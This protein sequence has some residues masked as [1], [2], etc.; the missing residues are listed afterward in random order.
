MKKILLI[1]GWLA[2]VVAALA[3]T[4][5]EKVS[6]PVA[7]Q[8]DNAN[9]MLR[10]APYDQTAFTR[11]LGNHTRAVSPLTD[12]CAKLSVAVFTT[13]G[14]K[15][16]NITQ[17]VGDAGYGT[18][19]LSLSAGTYR[20]V[21]IAHNGLG[22]AT[23]T[24]TEKVTFASN[25]VTD[26]FA[27]YGTLV[28]EEGVPIEQEVQMTRRVAM[29]RL[30]LSD[31]ALPEGVKRMKFYYTGGSSTYSPATGYGCVNSKQTEYRDCYDDDGEPVTVYELYTLPHEEND[32]LKMT[33]T[34]LGEGDE[35][36]YSTVFEN[37][38]VVRNKITTWT[39]APFGGDGGGP[40]TSGG[41]SITLDTGWD[42][43]L[44]YTF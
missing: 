12:Q 9:V 16:K 8:E 1:S 35:E 27:Y 42:G 20:L 24:S 17:K 18:V 43:T 11:S 39:G 25:K 31:G 5:C 32:V 7:G 40:I 28:V 33:I 19:S 37:V 13:D 44:N 34:A 36:I 4:A 2:A 23:I 29:V 26:T 14:T 30:T 10:F 38:P 41:I 22:T 21:A 6:L 15:A 3:L